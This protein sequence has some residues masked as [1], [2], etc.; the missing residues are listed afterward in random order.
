[1]LHPDSHMD[2]PTP[3]WWGTIL[4]EDYRGLE[5]TGFEDLSTR[6]RDVVTTIN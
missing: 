2:N 5:V 6:I 4:L 1:M 3:M